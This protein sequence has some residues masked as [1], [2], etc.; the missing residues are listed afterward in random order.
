MPLTVEQ[1][2]GQW[3]RVPAAGS[4]A[5]AWADGLDGVPSA[6]EYSL[7]GVGTWSHGRGSPGGTTS[8]LTVEFVRSGLAAA[9][10]AGA[11]RGGN[12]ESVCV[13]LWSGNDVALVQTYA[14]AAGQCLIVADVDMGSW[15]YEA[16]GRKPAAS[17]LLSDSSAAAREGLAALLDA[18]GGVLGRGYFTF[19][20]AARDERARARGSRPRMCKACGSHAFDGMLDDAGGGIICGE[21]CGRVCRGRS[22]GRSS[23]TRRRSPGCTRCTPKH[24]Q[25]HGRGADGCLADAL[26]ARNDA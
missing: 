11:G 19:T 10:A 25:R 14:A 24:A 3:L 23:R 4:V 18:D 1:T 15:S 12:A 8:G 21:L 2:P 13:M 6:D 20:W 7:H 5:A 16:L 9:A 17:G 26:A 22:R